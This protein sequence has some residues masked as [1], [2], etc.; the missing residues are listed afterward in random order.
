[1][2]ENASI[3]IEVVKG[4]VHDQCT[5]K[6]DSVSTPY[7]SMCA[8]MFDAYFISLNFPLKTTKY[9]RWTPVIHK[10]N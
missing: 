8:Y 4:E 10:E 7:K 2:L 5:S 3:F 9:Y 6:D 1:M